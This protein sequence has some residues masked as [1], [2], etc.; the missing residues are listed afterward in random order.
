MGR[1]GGGVVCVCV[2]EL[3]NLRRVCVY[4]C[5]LGCVLG[6]CR[7]GRCFFEGEG[8]D[9]AGVEKSNGGRKK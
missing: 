7:V 6:D 3:I 1:G 4:V 8:A 2:W 9:A 5:L